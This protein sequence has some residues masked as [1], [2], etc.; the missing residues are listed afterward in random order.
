MRLPRTR[1]ALAAALTAVN[2]HPDSVVRSLASQIFI[3]Q[4]PLEAKPH[5]EARRATGPHR[6]SDR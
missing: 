1:G 2:R 5:R 3:F 6:H 4:Q